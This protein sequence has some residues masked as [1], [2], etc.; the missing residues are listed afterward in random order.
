MHRSGQTKIVMAC[1]T[2]SREKSQICRSKGKGA[3]ATPK[4]TKRFVIPL[5]YAYALSLDI[6]P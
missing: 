5:L 3:C 1:S 2:I 4:K 6:L